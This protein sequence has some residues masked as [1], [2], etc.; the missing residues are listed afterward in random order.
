MSCNHDIHVWM[1]NARPLWASLNPHLGYYEPNPLALRIHSLGGE[2]WNVELHLYSGTLGP[3]SWNSIIGG[4]EYQCYFCGSYCAI[5]QMN[6][7]QPMHFVMELC[8]VLLHVYQTCLLK[9]ILC[10]RC[11][12]VYKELFFSCS[13]CTGNQVCYDVLTKCSYCSGS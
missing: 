12:V 7:D 4:T 1:L 13:C 8:A 2:H 9:G 11:L 10:A 3:W 5:F 6:S